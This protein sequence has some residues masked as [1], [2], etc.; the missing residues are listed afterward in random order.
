MF[1]EG[2]RVGLG[3]LTDPALR[4]TRTRPCDA[5]C[6]R[7]GTSG[8]LYGV[9]EKGRAAALT[10]KVRINPPSGACGLTRNRSAAQAAKQFEIQVQGGY[11]ISIM[12]LPSFA[13]LASLFIACLAI[14]VSVSRASDGDVPDPFCNVRVATISSEQ[15]YKHAPRD[16]KRVQAQFTKFGIKSQLALSTRAFDAKHRT[17]TDW[18]LYVYPPDAAKARHLVEW[19]KQHG[20]HVGPDYTPPTPLLQ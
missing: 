20:L 4:F 16:I 18:F 7:E 13:K 3:W 5:D 1:G 6:A 15:S 11:V 9:G 17:I 8:I 12:R 19:A 2:F 10:D 14:L